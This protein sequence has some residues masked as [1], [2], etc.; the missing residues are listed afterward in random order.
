MKP[1]IQKLPLSEHSSFMTGTFVTPHFETPWHYHPEYEIVLIIEGRGKSFI[2]NHVSDY[3]VGDLCC[4]GPNLPHVFRKD[5]PEREG[6]SL[7]RFCGKVFC[8]DS[9]NAEYT[10]AVRQVENGYPLRGKNQA[11]D[12][13]HHEANAAG[14][15]NAQV[16]FATEAAFGDGRI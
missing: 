10:V 11:G 13:H 8:V 2:G 14:A 4:L 12:E 5:D 3:E 6:G 9:R 7:G 15:G 16:H 1:Q